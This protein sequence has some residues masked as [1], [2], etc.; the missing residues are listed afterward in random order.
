MKLQLVMTRSRGSWDG[1]GSWGRRG[2][3]G[4]GGVVGGEGAVYKHL[5]SIVRDLLFTKS[6]D[7]WK[8]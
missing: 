5:K 2:S 3:W 6:K 7:S 1:E 8:E 4:G